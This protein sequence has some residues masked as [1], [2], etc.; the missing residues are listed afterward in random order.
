LRF[1]STLNA[2]DIQGT[3]NHGRVGCGCDRNKRDSTN[4]RGGILVQ[5]KI[6]N[7]KQTNGRR[8][9]GTD[10]KT[11]LT[12]AVSDDIVKQLRI[13]C[14][15]DDTSINQK[16]NSILM[17]WLFCY[18]A[19][20]L[21]GGIVIHPQT[22]MDIINKMDEESLVESLEHTARISPAILSQNDIPLTVNNLIENIFY[23]TAL[24]AGN[25][26]HFHHYIDDS[27]NISL[28]FE[29]SYG[30]K[31]SRILGKSICQF[32]NNQFGLATDLQTSPRNIKIL[33]FTK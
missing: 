6:L 8:S 11:N 3:S 12:L 14:N 18:R 10:R 9:A 22:W 16:V 23:K 29:H 33:I 4:C 17:R 5:L 2:K 27:D 26:S 15:S 30:L 19:I 24:Y 21:S 1:L 31:W 13:D 20:G 32:F 28:I 7:L 25:Y